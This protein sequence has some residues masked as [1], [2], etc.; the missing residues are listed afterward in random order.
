VG[1]GVVKRGRGIKKE[2]GLKGYLNL[3]SKFY[4]QVSL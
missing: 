4:V 1:N 2:K 3:K